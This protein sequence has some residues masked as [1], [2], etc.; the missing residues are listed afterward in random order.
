MKCFHCSNQTVTGAC[1]EGSMREQLGT[2]SALFD[3][4]NKNILLNEAI[5]I[6]TLEDSL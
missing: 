6:P 1:A 5:A 4:Q 2:I 3:V